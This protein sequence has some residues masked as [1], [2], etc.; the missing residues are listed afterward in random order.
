MNDLTLREGLYIFVNEFFHPSRQ[1]YRSRCGQIVN[2]L[3]AR[4]GVAFRER[5]HN[6]VNDISLRE[7]S[8]IF[9]K[10][11]LFR[12]RVLISFTTAIS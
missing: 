6:I 7:G 10:E 12:E 11:L 4:E 1:L 8:H 5:I 9:V 2:V 3:T